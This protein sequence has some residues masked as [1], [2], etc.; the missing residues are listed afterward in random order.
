MILI[1]LHFLIVLNIE[2][3]ISSFDQLV[4]K[5]FFFLFLDACSLPRI[6]SLSD[7]FFENLSLIFF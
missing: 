3:E 2:Y 5:V 6:N 1:L 7:L 4:V